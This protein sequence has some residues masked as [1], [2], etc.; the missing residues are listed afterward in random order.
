MQRH[1]TR[2]VSG[3]VNTTKCR[4]KGI[5]V[6]FS[7]KNMKTLKEL[8]NPDQSGWELVSE[9]LNEAKNEFEVL[10]KAEKRAENE[11]VNAQVTTRS[12]M[13]AIIYETGGILI[14][15]GWLR[16]LGS[17]SEKLDRGLTEWNKGKTFENYCDQ[18]SHF[19]IADDIIGGYFALNAGGIGSDIGKV[20]YL[21]QDTLEWECLDISY[22]EFIYWAL[23]GD[24]N[25]FYEIFRW[26]NWQIDIANANG[27]QVYSFVPFL[28][29]KEGKDIEKTDR[30]LVPI[31]ENYHLTL[32]FQKQ[33]GGN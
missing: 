20:Y 32:D 2:N 27:N 19:L 30:R 14:D 10:P 1:H 13:G 23:T 4:A 21:P 7:G 17:G 9:W 8:I 16:I 29:T 33:F 6:N 18:P 22:S 3:N 12:L 5:I 11:L 28:W 25:K 26:K 15:K 24:I 31:E